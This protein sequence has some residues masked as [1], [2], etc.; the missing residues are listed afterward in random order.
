MQNCQS[1]RPPCLDAGGDQFFAFLTFE[2]IQQSSNLLNCNFFRLEDYV[3]EELTRLSMAASTSP[4]LLQNFEISSLEY[5]ASKSS[6]RQ[7]FVNKNNLTE[8]DWLRLDDLQLTG[9]P[10]DSLSQRHLHFR[11]GRWQGLPRDPWSSGQTWSRKESV[12]RAHSIPA[13][14]PCARPS[15]ARLDFQE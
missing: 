10:C 1:V 11:D 12:G 14:C 13:K 5:V 7:V 3:L 8:L 4:V 15:C 9:V 6:V 2:Y